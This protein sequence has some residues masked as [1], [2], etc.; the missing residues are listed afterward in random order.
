MDRQ[1]GQTK[2]RKK[3]KEN[4]KAT[5]RQKSLSPATY[6]SARQYYFEKMSKKLGGS[7]TDESLSVEEQKAK[8]NDVRKMIGPIAAK[9]PGLCSD[10]SISRYLRA[11]N[12]NTKKAAKMLKDTMKWRLEFKPERIR[13]NTSATGG[14]IRHLVYCMDNAI[15]TMNPGEEQMV[16]LI[17][18]Q[19]WT[20]GSISIKAARETANVLQN[21]YPE[22]LGLA[23]LYNPPKVFE[24]FWTMVKPFI[25][26]K[27]Y[28]KVR[29]V[30]SSDPQSQKFMEE[31]FDMDKLD[32]AF[33]GRNSVGF[34]FEAYGQL[35]KE[36]ERKIYGSNNVAS[37]SPMLSVTSQQLSET[38]SQPGEGEDESS[39]GDEA[40]PNFVEDSNEYQ[41]SS[42]KDAANIDRDPVKE[43]NMSSGQC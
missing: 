2:K 43:L 41:Y 14:Q 17:D 22:R 7:I 3:N 16:W 34:N 12:W 26:P 37:V 35:M 21:R 29:F 25:E 4:I 40:C 38:S 6:V 9:H 30:Y 10:A 1:R 31:L 19:R 24:S 11:R 8:V 27:T 39:S 32:S 36:E 5:Y 15:M 13:W 28:K 42:C 20:M 23:I 18:F 33:G